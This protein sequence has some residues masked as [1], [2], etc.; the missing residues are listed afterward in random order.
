MKFNHAASNAAGLGISIKYRR[1]HCSEWSIPFC[2][3]YWWRALE[4]GFGFSSTVRI[5]L[6][7][8]GIPTTKKYRPVSI[9][10]PNIQ[11][12]VQP[13]T[14]LAVPSAKGKGLT[15]VV[16]NS[17]LWLAKWTKSTALADGKRCK[18]ISGARRSSRHW[19]L[20]FNRGYEGINCLLLTRR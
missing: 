5:T 7:S 16:P 13:C 2:T 19:Q 12:R 8:I 3:P 15:K 20:V 10:G 9:W 18:K 17:V 4:N 11:P 1:H 14:L 6:T